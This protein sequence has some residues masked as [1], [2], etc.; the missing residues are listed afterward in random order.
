M[1]HILNVENVFYSRCKWEKSL[2][3]WH[4]N[5]EHSL[6]RSEKGD[7]KNSTIKNVNATYIYIMCVALFC[8]ESLVK[9]LKGLESLD[10]VL[11]LPVCFKSLDILN[12]PHLQNY[13]YNIIL[14]I[15]YDW[16]VFKSW[17]ITNSKIHITV[18]VN[19]IIKIR[20]LAEVC[21]SN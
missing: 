18:L 9:H 16:H 4:L 14:E 6:K 15:Y 13:I 19:T 12:D 17:V 10:F 20:N 21:H 5:N 11:Y 2:T 8:E 7:I 3:N 1:L